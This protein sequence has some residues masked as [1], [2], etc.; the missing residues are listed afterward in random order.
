MRLINLKSIH[1]SPYTE[2][3]KNELYIT[4]TFKVRIIELEAGEKLPPDRPCEM[5]S[6]VIFNIL[7]GKTDIAVNGDYNEAEEGFCV[8]AE[9]GNYRL[10]AKTD[11]RILGIQIEKQETS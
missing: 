10:E 1:A 8:I 5:E 6:Y 9:P 2:R 7:S 4:D 11:C 3:H